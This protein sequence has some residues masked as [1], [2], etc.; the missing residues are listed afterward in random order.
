MIYMCFINEYRII[1]NL[2]IFLFLIFTY[3]ILFNKKNVH[4]TNIKKLR[5]QSN[6]F[7]PP[8]PNS[9]YFVDYS[10]NIKIGQIKPF[11]AFGKEMVVFRNQDNDIAILHAF[12]PHLGTHLGYEGKV[13]NNNIV[14]PY[15][16]W[17][18]DKDGLC[19]NIPYSK[20]KISDRCNTKKYYTLEKMGLIFVWYH[21]DNDPPKKEIDLFR[22]LDKSYRFIS[23]CDLD[24]MEMHIFE[25]SQ[26]SADYYHFKTVHRYLANP[27][28]SK[29]IE[30]DHIVTSNYNNPYNQII[31][32]ESVSSMKF[33]S[34]IPLPNFLCKLL[35]TIVVIETPSLIMFKIDNSFIGNFRAILTFTPIDKF[36]QKGKMSAWCNGWWPWIIGRILMYLVINT[37]YQDK[38]VWEH[39]LHVAP[40][41]WVQGDGPFASYSKWLDQFYSKSSQKQYSKLSEPENLYDW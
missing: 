32:N 2:F 8:Y 20:T 7:P 19:K 22:E 16:S 38:C 11:S 4:K 13:R 27:L 35:S 25:P 18:F 9:W 15:H 30:V 29:L 41:N 34:K 23:H 26:N 12:C 3:G 1:N 5:L 21:A 37:V 31:I 6:E 14:C 17:E 28:Y 24:D 36:Y 10:K 39:K 40:R 33:L